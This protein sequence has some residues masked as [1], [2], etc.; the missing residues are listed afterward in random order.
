MKVLDFEFFMMSVFSSIGAL[1]VCPCVHPIKGFFFLLAALC[2]YLGPQHNAM[3]QF[4]QFGP[5]IEVF[6]SG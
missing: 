3:K 5:Q 1:S 4:G 2:L 6:V